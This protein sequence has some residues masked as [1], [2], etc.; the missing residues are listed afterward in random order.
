MASQH[1]PG[2]WQLHP[3]H[4]Q[5]VIVNGSYGFDMK[6]WGADTMNPADAHLIA[7]APELLEAA[8]FALA[9][10]ECPDLAPHWANFDR[11]PRIAKL[12]AAIAKAEGE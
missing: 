11:E 1:T 5:R 9:A 6:S 10:L 12:R 7:A 8:N 2:P 3:E 4:N